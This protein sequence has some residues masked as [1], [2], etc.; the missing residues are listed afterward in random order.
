M[1]PRLPS[2]SQPRAV[3]SKAGCHR[4]A[5]RYEVSY[6]LLRQRGV[7]RRRIWRS[8]RLPR[9]AGCHDRQPGSGR[10]CRAV[11]GG[12]GV[13]GRHRNG[14]RP[15]RKSSGVSGLRTGTLVAPAG[16]YRITPGQTLAFSAGEE[17]SLDLRISWPFVA[18]WSVT[19]SVPS[20]SL[21]FFQGTPSGTRKPG[22]PGHARR[23]RHFARHV[24]FTP[25]PGFRRKHDAERDSHVGRR[26][27]NPLF[28]QRHRRDLRRHKRR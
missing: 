11:R 4:A 27:H 20:G 24:V 5:P 13:A 6:R 14:H 23:D 16:G 2:S 1:L 15:C 22:N 21:S 25:P 12:G 7:R 26:G 18:T 9:L 3:T 19:I 8:A 28:D 10:V 17:T